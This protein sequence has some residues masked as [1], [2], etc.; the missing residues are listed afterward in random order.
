LESEKMPNYAQPRPHQ[1]YIDQLKGVSIITG[2]GSSAGV[3]PGNGVAAAAQIKQIVDQGSRELDSLRDKIGFDAVA[4]GKSHIAQAGAE[5]ADYLMGH[6]MNDPNDVYKK[7]S[8][9]IA[10]ARRYAK[11]KI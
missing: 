3:R 1:K 8:D 7:D 9:A 2:S 4:I 11:L 10:E 6:Y 5:R